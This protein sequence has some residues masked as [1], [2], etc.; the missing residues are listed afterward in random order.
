MT[1]VLDQQTKQ[2]NLF[3]QDFVESNLSVIESESNVERLKRGLKESDCNANYIKAYSR[4]L[5][6]QEK[7]DIYELT[8]RLGNFAF[9]SSENENSKFSHSYSLRFIQLSKADII[10]IDNYTNSCV[11]A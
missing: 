2:V 10:S 4:E 5:T 6:A 9:L 7:Q 1:K 8:F 3:A 11:I